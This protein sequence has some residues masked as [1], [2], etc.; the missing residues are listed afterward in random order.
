MHNNTVY[1]II[2]NNY[3][4]K[5]V[6]TSPNCI[7]AVNEYLLTVDNELKIVANLNVQLNIEN[8]RNTGIYI[9]ILDVTSTKYP[10]VI[11]RLAL[12][13]NDVTVRDED[14]K[15]YA[16]LESSKQSE[17][18]CKVLTSISMNLKKIT[19]DQVASKISVQK[20]VVM[21]PSRVQNHRPQGLLKNSKRIFSRPM[22]TDIIPTKTSTLSNIP[23]TVSIHSDDS[24]EPIDVAKLQAQLDELTNLKTKKTEH[25]EL[26][27]KKL[28]DD[29][30]SYCNTFNNV[31]DER[32]FW[33]RDKEREEE[34]K[35]V[36]DSDKHVYSMIK[37]E[38]AN[39][40]RQEDN[41]PELFANKYPIFVALDEDELLGVDG[42]YELYTDLYNE[43]YP[44]TNGANSVD[45]IE[46]FIKNG[47]TGTIGTT[48]SNAQQAIPSLEDVLENISSDDDYSYI[49]DTQTN[50]PIETV[51]PAD[52]IGIN[53]L[54]EI[55][56][57]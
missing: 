52:D 46:E 28:E 50:E 44:T 9:L 10:F 49:A 56:F 2:D 16:G 8:I 19:G 14:D 42:D 34:K 32:R 31:N 20:R 57:D 7:D 36:F 23:D 12:N 51:E 18:T 47:T 41:I 54:Q 27:K 35:R 43:F 17:L 29:K 22:N 33:Q 55:T 25:L 6:F 4:L 11:G 15:I 39:G 53:N 48:V 30:E 26:M 38:I 5:Y 24:A 40:L 45:A 37:G 13:Y 1:A 3:P 21:P